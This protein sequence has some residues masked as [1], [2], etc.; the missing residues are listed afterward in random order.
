MPRPSII[1]DAVAR[2][3]REGSRGVDWIWFQTSSKVDRDAVDRWLVSIKHPS[4]YEAGT[5]EHRF[6]HIVREL[7]EKGMS[8]YGR[9]DVTRHYRRTRLISP[10]ACDRRS[11]RVKRVGRHGSFVTVCCPK[12]QWSPRR[13]R[14]K[15]GMRGQSFAKKRG[16]R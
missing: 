11:F 14:C 4:A 13:K 16:R 5:A 9:V 6:R 2:F 3:K 7:A 10:K 1:D 12:G 8:H 15:V